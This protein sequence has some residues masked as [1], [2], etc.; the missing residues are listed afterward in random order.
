M[1]R[2]MS[3]G[4]VLLTF[5]CAAPRQEEPQSSMATVEAQLDSLW[6][7][8]IAAAVAGDA[9]GIARL[10]V[11][12]ALV[13]ETGLATIRGGAA[14]RSVVT[15]VLGAVRFIE[16]EIR[17]DMTERAGNKVLQFGTYRDVLQPTGQGVQVVNGRFGAVLQRDSTGAWRVSRLVAVADSTVPQAPPPQ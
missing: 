5:A 15:D 12:D 10:Y 16:A 7:Q 2:R 17:P 1:S 9:E 4:M 8:Y 13:I 6:A 14:L 11:D 3:L